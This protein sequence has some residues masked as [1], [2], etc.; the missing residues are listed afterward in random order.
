MTYLKEK[1]RGVVNNNSTLWRL[2]RSIYDRIRNAPESRAPSW[3]ECP[4]DVQIDTLNYCNLSCKFCNV[5]AGGAYDIPRGRMS[6]EMLKYIIDYWAEY[7]QMKHICP[8]VNGEPLLDDRLPWI[9]EYSQKKGMKVI[10]DTNGTLYEHR[11]YLVH[12][13]MTL[14]RFSLSAITRETYEEV[15][16][17]DKFYEALNTFH[18]V[19]KKAYPSQQIELHFMVCKDNEH[20]VDDWIKYFEGFK[21]KIFPLHRMPDIQLASEDALGED[22]TWIQ[23][24]SS[25]E[26]WE[27]TRPLFIYPNGQRERQIMPKYKTCQGMAYAVMWDGTILQ[28]TDSPPSYNYGKVPEVDMLEAWHKRNRDRINSPACRACNAKR[29]DWFKTLRKLDLAT[30]EEVEDYLQWRNKNE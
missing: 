5:K 15:H 11:D 4:Q 6:D 1:L 28:C 2:K 10:V 3:V 23:D 9:C 12:P 22:S 24:V 27:A 16:G 8:Y 30:N 17:A 25:Q 19:A 20:E 29:P 14:V 7:P 18:Y 21:R 13:N 26:A